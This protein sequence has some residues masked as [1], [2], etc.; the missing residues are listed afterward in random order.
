[1]KKLVL[2]SLCTLAVATGAFA[3]GSVNWASISAAFLTAQIN[4]Q[5]SAFTGGTPTTTGGVVT[6]LTGSNFYYELLFTSYTGSAAPAPTSFAS[7]STW[8]DSGLEATNSNTAGRLTTIG[9]LAGNN[10]TGF[11]S[12]GSA[13]NSVMLVGWSANLGTTY[14]TALANAQSLNFTGTGYFG[15]SSVGYVQG[16]ANGAS[17]GVTVFGN[18]TV[19][20]SG[21]GIYNSA[22]GGGTPMQLYQLT[23]TST[24]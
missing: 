9:Q 8:T 15:E 16:F 19:G 5:N 20:A 11:S 12:G 7:L 21:Q 17:P 6:G 18:G 2:T 23:A 22:T 10:I 1:M 14:A 24:K 3:Q 13:T 4:A